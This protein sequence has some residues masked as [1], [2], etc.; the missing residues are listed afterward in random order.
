MINTKP[1]TKDLRNFGLTFCAV[2]IAF[3]GIVYWKHHTINTGLL[4]A[5]AF[6][7][8][9]GLIFPRILKPLQIGWMAFGFALGWIN[10]RLVLGIIFF[11][12][13]TPVGLLMRATGKD[14]LNERIDK[15]RH[16]YWIKR[17]RSTVDKKRY[18]QLF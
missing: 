18:E 13:F 1:S 6:F 14:L 11:V 8:L 5:S 12:V 9:S 7:L 10:T 4:A 15:S 3:A 2:F 16:S 17:D